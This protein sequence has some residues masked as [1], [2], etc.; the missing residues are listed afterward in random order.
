MSGFEVEK[1]LK[2]NRWVALCS[3]NPAARMRLFCFP[4]AGGAAS[5]FRA[6]ADY[7]PPF[8]EVCPVQLPGRAGRLAETP[9]ERLPPLLDAVAEGLDELFD[10]P[11]ALFGHSMG[12]IISFEL[13]RLRARRGEPEPLHLFIS[14]R[15]APQTPASERITY[16]LPEPEFIEQLRT[17]GGTPAEALEHPELLQLM[18]PLLRA[19]FGVC[20][21]YEYRPGPKLNC[22]VTA[23]GGLG[24][25][26]VSSQSLAGW[27]EQTTGRFT[28]RMLPGDH[29]FLHTSRPLLLQTLS[30]ELYRDATNA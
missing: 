7:V 16:N 11:Y 23:W 10:K 15:G 17:L 6:W 29:F 26:E 24:D 19:D 2:A 12:A 25:R 22:P 28:L 3:H 14:A 27:G 1:G 30:Q 21:T 13:A 5:I 8:V 9:F 4:Y 20:Q 18:L